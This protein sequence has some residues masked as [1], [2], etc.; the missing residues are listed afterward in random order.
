MLRE[1]TARKSYPENV[2]NPTVV[3]QDCVGT[4]EQRFLDLTRRSILAL[5]NSCGYSRVAFQK[6]SSI[7]NLEA[8]DEAQIQKTQKYNKS[9]QPHL[10]TT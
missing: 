2:D 1:K 6:F 9:D 10:D 4:S 3:P 5:S 8:R 7:A